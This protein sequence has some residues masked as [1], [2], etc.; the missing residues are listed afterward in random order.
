[1]LNE[2]P[3]D[4]LH[5]VILN[6][7]RIDNLIEE[8]IDRGFG[9][10]HK[11]WDEKKI[12]EVKVE[13]FN[14]YLF[15]DIGASTK[16]DIAEEIMQRDYPYVKLPKN[17]KEKFIRFYKIRN[18][19]AHNVELKGVEKKYLPELQ[20]LNWENLHKEHEK[21]YSEIMDLFLKGA[22]TI[23]SEKGKQFFEI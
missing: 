2:P 9:F 23:A 8:I 19:F 16:F 10:K 11:F 17:L 21:I 13:M 15:Q 12:D 7:I 20:E 1:M 14:K 18:I 3:K 5:D 6:T 22:E 4:L